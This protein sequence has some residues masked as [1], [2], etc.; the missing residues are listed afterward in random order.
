MLLIKRILAGII[1]LFVFVLIALVLFPILNVA[2]I[3][4]ETKYF[5]LI[6]FV[7]TYIIPILYLKTS[8]GYKIF[9]IP[10]NSSK[11]LILKYLIYYFLIS[12]IFIRII[13]FFG[14]LSK[15]SSDNFINSIT[16]IYILIALFLISGLLFLFSLGRYNLFDFILKIFYSK[17]I[18]K[19][20]SKLFLVIW[21]SIAYVIA[22]VSIISKQNYIDDYLNQFVKVNLDYNF[23]N[24]YPKDVFD[25]FIYFQTEKIN[26][27]N[28]I[29]T[30]SDTKSFYQ[31]T[32]LGQKTIY[33]IINKPTFENEIKRYVLCNY[34]IN[35][36]NINDIF[37]DV[38]DEV[39]QTKLLLIY[40]EPQTYFSKKIYTYCYY[41]D[42]KNPKYSI[43]GGI[44]LD[45][46]IA[47]QKSK[48]GLKDRAF[49][50]ALIKTL[51][52]SEDSLKKI[53]Q[54]GSISLSYEQAD[55]LK[56]EFSKLINS[57]SNIPITILPFG[58]VKPD[59]TFSI[60]S[61]RSQA[62]QIELTENYYWNDKFFEAIFWRDYIDSENHYTQ[63]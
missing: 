16:Y 56:K 22:F 8:I 24:Y 46:L 23:T 5:Y 26:L 32:F 11:R 12:G 30:F 52:I 43:Y 50:L 57:E 62:H 13:I 27:N 34:L 35:Y 45:S 3:D 21:F 15:Y 6:L 54:N 31:N 37:N 44:A 17:V 18:Y 51:K 28:D 25:E 58:S 20:S 33:A 29:I 2:K 59:E 39:S 55:L 48:I 1:N 61:I 4:L 36:S 19:R 60:N 40:N 41:Y 14:E 42:N 47:Y 49:K 53:A 63:Q 9:K 38:S 10:C 7:A